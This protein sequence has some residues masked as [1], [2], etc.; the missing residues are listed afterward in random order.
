MGLVRRIRDACHDRRTV[1]SVVVVQIAIVAA[2]LL[3]LGYVRRE[4]EEL[5]A[6]LVAL[7][8]IG[9]VHRIRDANDLH[10]VLRRL[11]MLDL[12]D[13]VQRIGFMEA[14]GARADLER[15]GE[16]PEHGAGYHVV[17][18]RNAR[19]AERHLPTQGSED[20]GDRCPNTRVLGV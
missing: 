2:V 6:V 16:R 17:D 4:L 12:S 11:E 19:L 15:L 13:E 5:L 14:I 3:K 8:R 18:E 7:R 10:A 20:W 1:L 9:V